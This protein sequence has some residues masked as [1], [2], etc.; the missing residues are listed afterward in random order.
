[1][2]E[3]LPL[4]R[5]ID[6]SFVVQFVG[7][8]EN[9]MKVRQS[10]SVRDQALY[11][12]FL[13]VEGKARQL[14]E[15]SQG[16]SHLFFTPHGWSHVSAVEAN[17]DWLLSDQD[18]SRLNPIEIFVLLV[19]T[20]FHD[21]MMIPAKVGGEKTARRNHAR[22]AGDFLQKNRDF[23]ALSITEI[24]PIAQTILGHALTSLRDLPEPYAVGNLLVDV[25]M[26]A[27]CLSI[28]DICHADASRAPEVLLKRLDLDAES[29][30]HWRRHLQISG[31][32]RKDNHIVLSTVCFSEEGQQ[33]VAGYKTEIERQIQGVRPYFDSVLTPITHVDL[34]CQKAESPLDVTLRFQANTS[35]ILDL[36]IA[37]VYERDDVFLRE[38]VQNSL[39]ACLIHAARAFKRTEAYEPRIVITVLTENGVLRGVRV[40]DNGIG[41][42]VNDLEDTVLWIGNSISRRQDV[43]ELLRTTV[44]RDLIATF[45]IGL[46]SCFRSAVNL[47]VRSA[48]EG[49]NSIEFAV[50]SISDAIR[51]R[52]SPDTSVGTTILLDLKSELAEEIEIAESAG[53]FFRMVTR[54]QLRILSLEWGEA[55]LK[56][57]REQLFRIASTEGV[58]LAPSDPFASLGIFTQCEIRAEDYMCTLCVPNFDLKSG[59]DGRIEVLSEGVFVCSDDAS[60]WLPT[61]LHGCSG[62]LNFAARSV[63]LPV[64]R[65]RVAK[66]KKLAQKL[67]DLAAHTVGLLD[68]LVE[69]TGSSDQKVGDEAALILTTWHRDADNEWKRSI[70]QH[71]SGMCVRRYQ[72]RRDFPLSG[73]QKNT[74]QEIFLEYTQG[75]WV[76]DLA[77]VDGKQLWHKHDDLTQ[78]QAAILAQEGQLVLSCARADPQD[79][80]VLEANLLVAYFSD[81]AVRV[82]DLTEAVEVTGRIRSKP[83]PQMVRDA[84]PDR[85]KFIEVPGIPNRRAWRV[86]S[87]TWVNISNPQMAKLYE[88]VRAPN[89]DASTAAILQILV[90]MLSYQYEDALNG[91]LRQMDSTKGGR[92]SG[93]QV[94]HRG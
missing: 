10:L 51:P 63:D 37:G 90:Q 12:R 21:A 15:Y 29:A 8:G 85:V 42:D 16:G 36:L 88:R 20:L 70:L 68:R 64:S 56:L 55:T 50:K 40:D 2:A 23:L 38:L 27:A 14:L 26:L 39:D 82:K 11:A 41:M 94:D 65:D 89:L 66:N 17:Y 57:T 73:I 46:L 92:S 32:T 1:L 35:A 47:E 62:R 45:G 28:A 30:L 43:Q 53:Y 4:G 49:R 83:V 48:K 34:T 31:I 59:P 58:P 74:S 72:G 19:S 25:R 86:K 7:S 61:H 71:L 52:Q 76:T 18:I 5:G 33:A 69:L 9:A 67:G 3:V 13:V 22:E 91:L 24:A 79:E 84:L 77:V 80:R 78:L 44:G 60:S 75:R 81:T 93:Q 6:D 87:E 54:P